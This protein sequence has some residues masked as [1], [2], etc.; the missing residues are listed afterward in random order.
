MT[1]NNVLNSTAGDNILKLA[2]ELT[3]GPAGYTGPFPDERREL[4]E[5]VTG[6]MDVTAGTFQTVSGFPTGTVC[7]IT[8]TLPWLRPDGYSFGTPTFT[9]T[10]GTAD[11]GV[12]TIVGFSPVVHGHDPQHAHP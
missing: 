4:R 3:G 12:V 9:E 5:G 7:T 8:E 1:V 10:S 6:S 11:D 2:K